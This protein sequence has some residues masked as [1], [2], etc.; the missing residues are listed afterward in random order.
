MFVEKTELSQPAATRSGA[1]GTLVID[2]GAS[3]A[4]R[5]GTTADLAE[6]R[7]QMLETLA[8]IDSAATSLSA[9]LLTSADLSSARRA[10]RAV[11]RCMLL[12]DAAGTAWWNAVFHQILTSRCPNRRMSELLAEELATLQMT[13]GPTAPDWAEMA[14]AAREHAT[15]LW[16]AQSCPGSGEIGQLMR[17]HWRTCC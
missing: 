10:H 6:G 12:R 13:S 14:R 5:A 1:T 17:A 3:G 16:L 11:E 8:I 15:L 7:R 9:P 2:I 4:T